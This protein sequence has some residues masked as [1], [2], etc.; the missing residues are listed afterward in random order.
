MKTKILKYHKGHEK[1]INEAIRN[2][3]RLE[4]NINYTTFILKTGKPM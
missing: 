2:V 3:V 1:L 4:A